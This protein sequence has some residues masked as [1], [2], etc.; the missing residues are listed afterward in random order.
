MSAKVAAS[1]VVVWTGPG[2]APLVAQVLDVMG[3]AVEPLGV[4]GPRVGAVADLAASLGCGYEDDLRKLIVE[5]PASFLL[6]AELSGA[7]VDDLKAAAAQ[8]TAILCLEPPAGDFDTLDQIDA[9]AGSIHLLPAFVQSPGSLAAA[10]PAEALGERRVVGFDSAGRSATLFARLWD[11]WATALSYIETP[12]SIDAALTSGSAAG[13]VAEPPEQLA[14]LS[15]CL[16]AHGRVA[17]GGSVV[18]ELADAAG[19]DRRSLHVV[20]EAT[21]LRVEDGGYE[22]HQAGG[23]L[24]D[25][26]LTD[27]PTTW[28]DLIAHQWRRRLDRPG[29]AAGSNFR[30]RGDVLACCLATLL[31]TRTGEPESPADLRRMHV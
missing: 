12:Q 30:G 14:Q 3:A 19:S 29:A 13:A 22:L 5:H 31:S 17:S 27:E 2:R 24:L 8:N 4:G 21:E 20:S 25:S 11:A 15:G 7:S 10:N 26:T 23:K 6:L 9:I 18:L 28:A 1:E 16:T